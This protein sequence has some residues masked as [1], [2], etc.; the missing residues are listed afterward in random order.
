MLVA[1]TDETLER[2]AIL[3]V[4][5]SPACTARSDGPFAAKPSVGAGQARCTPCAMEHESCRLDLRRAGRRRWPSFSCS[6]KSQLRMSRSFE[7]I[8]PDQRI[9]SGVS[10][11]RDD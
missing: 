10:E 2:I 9:G 4:A 6:D 1:I 3:S 7:S 8:S 11:H 5:R